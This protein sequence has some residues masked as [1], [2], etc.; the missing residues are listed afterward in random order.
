M[1]E[2]ISNR[3]PTYAEI[4]LDSLAFNLHSV[5]AFLRSDLLYMAVVKANAYGHGAVECSR[6]LEREGADWFGVASPDEGIELRLNGITKPVL[7]FGGPWPGEE[8]KLLQN[9]I[10]PVVF[11]LS[12]AER[13]SQAA[14]ER[15]VKTKIHVEIDTGM[16]RVGVPFENVAEFA[17][18]LR[19]IPELEVEGV[20]T[21]FASADDLDET[22]FTNSQINKFT[23]AVE[24]FR[25]KGFAPS[26]ID[27]ANS[28]GAV[29]HPASH[30][31]MV[32]LGGI[33]YG[34]GGDV[35]PPG[36]E[37]PALRPVMSV[38]SA[39]SFIK[40]VP[41]GSSLGYGRTFVTERDSVIGTLPIG[42]HDG[43]RRGLSNRAHV[44]VNGTLAPV[45]GRISM[46][47]TMIDLTEIPESKVGDK[48]TLIG[49]EDGR[50]IR[51]ED[52]AAPLDTI[53]YEITCGISA[54]VPR[55]Y[56]DADDRKVPVLQTKS[57]E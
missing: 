10:T 51:A 27:M 21:H 53:S 23:K 28:P 34:L 42:Y 1:S 31:N 45:V 47:W 44:L 49:T 12:Y 2:T 56:S 41:K 29:A 32:R 33:L 39:I 26:I 55:H 13:V 3:R 20:M 43:Y 22:E 30:G 50:S 57:V 16:G 36:I 17:E 24:I 19:K 15:G 4:D 35:L 40:E 7:S 25:A 46:D 6:R 8:G 54:R 9:S 5:K 48:V 14:R 18:Q 52:L 11:D 38:V 37:H